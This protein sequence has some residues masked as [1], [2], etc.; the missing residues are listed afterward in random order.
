MSFDISRYTVLV[1]ADDATALADVAAVLRRA[2]F[3]VV[4]VR[5]SDAALRELAAEPGRYDAIVLD[6]VVPEINALAVLREAKA[7]VPAGDIPIVML[8]AN[9]GDADSVTGLPAGALHRVAKPYDPKHLVTL[10]RAAMEAFRSQ[11]DLRAQLQ[12]QAEIRD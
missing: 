1:A 11:V 7:S 8:S 3:D 10:L 12:A 4:V 2:D 6:C 5:S 9:S